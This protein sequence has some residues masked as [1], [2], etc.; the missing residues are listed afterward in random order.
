[1][2]Q[3]QNTEEF[4]RL[5]INAPRIRFEYRH[6]LLLEDGSIISDSDYS[7]EKLIFVQIYNGSMM[8][9]YFITVKC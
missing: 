6:P 8:K 5:K 3:I 7:I 1:M 9:K 4:P 2:D